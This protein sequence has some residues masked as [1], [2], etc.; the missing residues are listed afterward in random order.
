MNMVEV[1]SISFYPLCNN[2]TIKSHDHSNQCSYY[3]LLTTLAVSRQEIE[4][5][6]NIPGVE[7]LSFVISV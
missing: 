7:Y 2:S 5:Q 6:W 1:F 3:Q 4:G